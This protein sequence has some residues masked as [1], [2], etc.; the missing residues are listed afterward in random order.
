MV[1]GAGAARRAP[2]RINE[3]LEVSTATGI[4]CVI[5]L[6]IHYQDHLWQVNC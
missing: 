2:K 3:L 4:S 5:R 6:V 1:V